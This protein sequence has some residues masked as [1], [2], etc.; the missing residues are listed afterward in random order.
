MATSTS[1]RRIITLTTD[2]GTADHFVGVMKGV[3]LGIAPDVRIIDITHEIPPFEIAQGAFLIAEASR[4][5][6]KKTIHVVVVD[7]G[8]GTARRPVL[9]EANDQYFIAPDNGVLAMVYA[10]VPHKAR[11]ITAA[12]IL[13]RPVSRT[14]H[15]RDIFAPAAAWLAAGM[16]PASMGKQ[17][18]DHLKLAFQTPQRTARRVWSGTVLHIDR[19]GNLITNFRISEFEGVRTRPFQIAIGPGAISRLAL[20]Y[21]DSD[22]GE[23]VVVEGSSGFLEISVNQSSAARALGCGVGAPVE[24]TLF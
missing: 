3:I 16:R 6:S 13:S 7:P 24:L 5:F 1:S 14:F 9:I 8:V 23:P 19:F 21:A 4:W 20:T 12:K 2:F 17:I 11:E 15:G 18:D 22:P 10:D